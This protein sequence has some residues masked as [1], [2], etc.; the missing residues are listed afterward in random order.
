LP[1]RKSETADWITVKL[2]GKGINSTEKKA[3]KEET[4]K[5]KLLFMHQ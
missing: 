2:N 5:I 3:K 4:W 1:K